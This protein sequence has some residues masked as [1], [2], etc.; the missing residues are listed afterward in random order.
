METLGHEKPPHALG[1]A[2]AGFGSF[3]GLAQAP[4]GHAV[5]PVRQ[6]KPI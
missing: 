1:D 2:V 3:E 5:V 6:A 4:G